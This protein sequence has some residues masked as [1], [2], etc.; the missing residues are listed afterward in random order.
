[1]FAYH[2][3]SPATRSPY[4]GGPKCLSDKSCKSNRGCAGS[5][6]LIHVQVG[7]SEVDLS[8][9]SVFELDS[10]SLSFFSDFFVPGN[11]VEE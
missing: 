8:A 2:S 1:M 6:L 11:A 7:Q 4:N 10:D 9:V 5:P 3:C